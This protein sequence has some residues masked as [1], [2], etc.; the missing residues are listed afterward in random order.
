MAQARGV[1]ELAAN[2]TQFHS[3]LANGWRDG[4]FLIVVLGAPHDPEA[5]AGAVQ[6]HSRLDEPRVEA[7]PRHPGH[8]A[9]GVD[10]YE[11][12]RRPAAREYVEI[13]RMVDQIISKAEGE[14]AEEVV[15]QIK[16]PRQK[17]G[18]DAL[19]EADELVGTLSWQ[20][21]LAD[22]SKLDESVGYTFGRSVTPELADGLTRRPIGA[23]VLRGGGASGGSVARQLSRR[24]LTRR[25]PH[26]SGLV[27][28]GIGDGRGVPVVTARDDGSGLRGTRNWA[29]TIRN[30]NQ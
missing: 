1:P 14:E 16:A 22:G 5:R 19:R 3:L 29:K 27:R 26:L 25:D 20:P 18:A 24:V 21:T 7:R 4:R 6:W 28:G 30:R 9:R 17:I 10:T 11:V 12:E 13:A 2:A 8:R 15:E 23:P